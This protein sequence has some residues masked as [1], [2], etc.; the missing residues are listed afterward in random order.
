MNSDKL[1]RKQ[2]GECW[3]LLPPGLCDRIMVLRQLASLGSGKWESPG[4]LPGSTAH[5]VLTGSQTSLWQF[6][7]RPQGKQSQRGNGDAPHGDSPPFALTVWTWEGYGETLVRGWRLRRGIRIHGKVRRPLPLESY[8][9]LSRGCLARPGPASWL[10]MR[11][12]PSHLGL[13]S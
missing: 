9:L 11:G 5:H 8:R 1:R 10:L 6:E 13:S 2:R 7:G 3:K 4:W 12:L